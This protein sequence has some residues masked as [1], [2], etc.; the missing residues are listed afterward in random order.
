[1]PARDLT[2]FEESL[3][4]GAVRGRARVP[5]HVA[6]HLVGGLH[7]A[8]GGFGRE[9]KVPAQELDAQGARPA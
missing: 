7:H 5:G 6:A 9:R 8:G 4:V 2:Q 3:D 1:M